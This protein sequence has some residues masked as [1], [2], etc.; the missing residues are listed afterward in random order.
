MIQKSL[1]QLRRELVSGT[2]FK[3]RRTRFA[4]AGLLVPVLPVALVRDVPVAVQ[5]DLSHRSDGHVSIFD[6]VND[7]PSDVFVPI[8]SRVFG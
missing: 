5:A 1:F 6:E 2:L 3:M 4:A 7:P 8:I